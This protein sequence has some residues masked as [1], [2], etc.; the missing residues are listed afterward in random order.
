MPRKILSAALAFALCVAP[1]GADTIN[2][3]NWEQYIDQALLD[4]W[5]AKTGV[6]VRQTYYDSGDAREQILS[7]PLSNVDLV[8]ISDNSSR[9]YGRR[10]VLATLDSAEVPSLEEQTPDLRARCGPFGAPY[11]SGTMGIIYRSDKVSV[12]PT[13]WMDL[14][15]PPAALRGHVAMFDDPMEMFVAPLIALG[16]SIN[17]SDK[18]T[19]KA[20]FDLLKAQATSVRTYD[21]VLT[22]S[23]N[24]SY[25]DQIFMALGYSGDQYALNETPKSPGTWRFVIP[26]EGSLYWL[27]CLSVVASSPRKALALDLLNHIT[28]APGALANAVALRRPTPNDKALAQ[29][30]DEMRR[31]EAIYPP[32]DVLARS[33]APQELTPDAIQIRRRIISTLENFRDAR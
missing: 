25:G 3:L 10:G 16:K 22:S 24:E 2:L 32:A 8:V 1:A 20:V 4:A 6:A 26:K 5:S 33:E 29:I 19:M 17:A 12:A 7:D 14:M 9:L 27:D 30:P 11:F 23:Q 18:D 31:D 13:S 28:S 15:A 21:Y